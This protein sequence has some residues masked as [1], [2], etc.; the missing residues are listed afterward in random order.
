MSASDLAR[1]AAGTFIEDVPA[2][3][4]PVL[5]WLQEECRTGRFK[6]CVTKFAQGQDALLQPELVR[7]EFVTENGII[8]VIPG[9]HTDREDTHT[10]LVE[11]RCVLDPLTGSLDSLGV[12]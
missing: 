8:C 1:K 11:V 5:R 2:P 9:R 3:G 12:Q 4:S 10:Y 6:E 7:V